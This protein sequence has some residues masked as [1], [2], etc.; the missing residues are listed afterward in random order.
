MKKSKE[1]KKELFKCSCR[2]LRNFKLI[3][4]FMI[5]LNDMFLSIFLCDTAFNKLG[6]FYV[7]A[8]CTFTS[9]TIINLP[10]YSK[11]YL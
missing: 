9:G 6:L 1:K 8:I 5:I 11:R 10:C 2:Y 3:Y 7:I 4:A